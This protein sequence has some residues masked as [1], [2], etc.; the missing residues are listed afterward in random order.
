MRFSGPLDAAPP[1]SHTAGMNGSEKIAVSL[2]KGV[3]ERTRRAL[4]WGGAAGALGVGAL[5]LVSWGNP[6]PQ[7][8]PVSFTLVAAFYACAIGLTVVHTGHPWL[9]VLRHPW[10]T[11][12]GLVSYPLYLTHLPVMHYTPVLLARPGITSDAVLTAATW[13]GVCAA[14]IALHRFVERPAL[15]MKSRWSYAGDAREER[16]GP[17]PS[18]L[19][20]SSWSV[21]WSLVRPWSWGR[22]ATT[23]RLPRSQL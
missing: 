3:A 4:W 8:R 11:R 15:A 22:S 20:L 16:G 19:V 9:H 14:A 7:W 21:P 10:L 1:L 6:E 17:G 5:A 2:P 23:G 18:S 13:V 12:L